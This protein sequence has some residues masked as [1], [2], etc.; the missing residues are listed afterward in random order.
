MGA[1]SIYSHIKRSNGMPK[2]DK[3]PTALGT[4][5]DVEKVLSTGYLNKP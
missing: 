5:L 3:K 2:Y 4:A 1:F